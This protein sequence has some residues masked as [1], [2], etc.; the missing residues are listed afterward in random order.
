MAK[1]IIIYCKK[2]GGWRFA[3]K[4]SKMVIRDAKDEIIFY[5]AEGHRIEEIDHTDDINVDHCTCEKG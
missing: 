5:L 2:C 4:K 3:A 1:I